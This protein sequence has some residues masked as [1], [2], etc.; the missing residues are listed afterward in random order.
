MF[1]LYLWIFYKYTITGQAGKA[2]KLLLIYFMQPCV[3]LCD[4][5]KNGHDINFQIMDIKKPVTVAIT[6]FLLWSCWADL[7]RRPHPYQG[8][9]LP[10]E[11]QQHMATKMGLE[12]TTSSVTGWRSNQLNYLAIIFTGDLVELEL[13]QYSRSV[14]RCQQKNSCFLGFFAAQLD[15]HPA[16]ICL[17]QGFPPQHSAC[18]RKITPPQMRRYSHII[19]RRGSDGTYPAFSG[20]WP[21]FHRRTET[22]PR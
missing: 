18:L 6:R 12:P 20:Q 5:L 9:A 11:L 1:L 10:T 4:L 17:C 2:S 16:H 21:Q 7:N 3:L 8:C 14:L 22:S 19:W 13:I 15:H